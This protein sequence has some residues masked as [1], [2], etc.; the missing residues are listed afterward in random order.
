MNKAALHKTTLMQFKARQVLR[1]LFN[2]NQGNGSD[3]KFVDGGAKT[4]LKI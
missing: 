3:I 1:N 4:S 2:T